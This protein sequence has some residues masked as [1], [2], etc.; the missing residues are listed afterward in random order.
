[1]TCYL[2]WAHY[3]DTEPSSPCPL[4]IMLSAGLGSDKYQSESHWFDSTGVKIHKV[5]IRT[6]NNPIPRSSS[7]GDGRSTHV[8]TPYGGYKQNKAT[9]TKRTKTQ[10]P[11]RTKSYENIAN[12][13]SHSPSERLAITLMFP[14]NMRNYYLS[15]YVLRNAPYAIGLSCS[16]I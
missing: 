11:H 1:M 15:I 8:A 5:G 3:T 14:L 4:L 10:P 7:I 6:H 16:L 12:H 9:L 2:T 13:F